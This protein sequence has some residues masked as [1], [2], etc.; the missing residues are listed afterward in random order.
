MSTIATTGRFWNPELMRAYYLAENRGWVLK[1]AQ[2]SREQREQ[3]GL[4]AVFQSEWDLG[5]QPL[6]ASD[7]LDEVR[8]FLRTR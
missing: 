1:A 4:Y 3:G 7:D 2:S 8:Q 6:K 5:L